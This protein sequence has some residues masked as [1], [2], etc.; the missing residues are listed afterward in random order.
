MSWLR[1][2]NIVGFG[3]CAGCG[4]ADENIVSHCRKKKNGSCR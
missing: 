4:I 2:I 3:Q 1:D